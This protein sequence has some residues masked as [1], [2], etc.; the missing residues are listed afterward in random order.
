[1]RIID[2]NYN[3]I[4]ESEADLEKG[5]LVNALS[6]REDAKPIDNI[7]KFAWSDDDYEEVKMYR[8]YTTETEPTIQDEMDSV[9][10]DLEY[11]VTL[12]ELGIS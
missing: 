10:I 12:L 1:M 11:R 8:L 3:T 5:F 4:Q 7:T 9:L 2:E 6:V